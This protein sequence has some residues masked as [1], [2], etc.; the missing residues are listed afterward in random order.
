MKSLRSP[1]LSCLAGLF[2]SAIA[3]VAFADEPAHEEEATVHEQAPPATKEK[4][5]PAEQ[6]P[7][8]D[9]E[10]V[11]EKP[12]ESEAGPTEVRILGES[13]EQLQKVP[14]SRALV[15]AKEIKRMAPRDASEVIRR[16][17]SLTVASEDGH[18]LRLNVGMRG[19]DPTRSRSILVL[20]DGVPISINPYG[21]PDLYYSTTVDRIRAVELVKGSGAVLYGPQTIAGVLNFITPSPP[22]SREAL[23][24]MEGGQ[25]GFFHALARY[26]DA[27]GDVRYMA[28]ASFRRADGPRDIGLDA[29]DLM[30][31]VVVPTSS[32]GEMLIKLGFY[33]ERSG[34]TYVGMTRDMFEADPEQPSVA[35]HDRFDVQRIEA[36]LVHTQ[37]LTDW[38]KL[39][40]L[41]YGYLTDRVWRRQRYD[42]IPVDGIDYERVVGNPDIP[43]GAIYFRNNS[44]IRDRHYQVAGIE[45]QVEMKG[46]TGPVR[47]TLTFGARFHAEFAQREQRV[48]DF[49]TSEAGVPELNEAQRVLAGSAYVQDRMAFTDWLLVT[50][51]VRFELAGYER[52]TLREE[53]D[54]VATDVDVHG[55]STAIGAIPGLGIVVGTPD[56]NGFGGI[57]LGWSPPRVS[58]AVTP[59]GRDAQLSAERSTSI[60]AGVRGRPVPGLNFEATGFLTM[61]TNQIVPATASSGVQSELV[62]GGATRHAGVE[63]SGTVSIGELAGVDFDLDV[64]ARYTFA[65]ARYRGGPFDGN[66]LPYAPQHHASAVVDFQHPFGPGAQFSWSFVGPQF[67][68]ETNSE[69]AD[70][71]GRTGEIDIQNVLDASI[72][73]TIA[74]VGLTPYLSMKNMLNDVYISSRRPDGIHTAG[75]RQII[76]GL[77]WEGP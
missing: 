54:G 39:R 22:D 50:P 38:A 47:H 10:L 4:T 65:D 53:V 20:E 72:R 48:T 56:F 77:R 57:H 16:V 60:E 33:H 18:G 63:A 21:E 15:T 5:A 29:V 1:A 14:G 59:D 9:A 6:A 55:T 36:S 52:A 25:F 32:R 40:T 19:F 46:L 2:V 74:Q 67:T 68:D 45:P 44:M 31:K 62:N 27:Q 42:R 71:T 11:A 35:P 51:G 69:L 34:S 12:A 17:P 66:L 8:A 24:V 7:P 3:P 70:A 23:A 28:Q 41:V 49:I 64:T 26:G 75:F 30:G 58:S 43:V 76:G 73:W 61:F 37:K 13:D